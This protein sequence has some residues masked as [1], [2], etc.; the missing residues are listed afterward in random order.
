VLELRARDETDP[1]ASKMFKSS[2]DTSG[3]GPV[4]E[5][6]YATDVSA[7]L[8]DPE[9]SEAGADE[10]ADHA[11]VTYSTPDFGACPNPPPHAPPYSK[12]A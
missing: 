8:Q 10:I 6:T 9:L 3:G 7:Y 12:L 1:T 11:N 5:V 2:D 4:L